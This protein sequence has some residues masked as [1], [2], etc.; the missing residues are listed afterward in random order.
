M[1]NT[2]MVN[3]K[4]KV[5][6]IFD[7]GG[8]SFDRYTIAFK[9]FRYNGRMVYPYFAASEKPFHPQ[10]LGQYG[11]STLFLTGKHLGKRVDFADI[12]EQ[13]KKLILQSI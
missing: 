2:S 12:P 11:E 9:G 3:G 13:V 10:G 7:N 4:R 6:R 8:L 5:C 1:K